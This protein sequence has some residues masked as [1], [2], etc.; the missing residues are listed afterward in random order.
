VLALL[1]WGA[2]SAAAK[3]DDDDEAYFGAITYSPSTRAHGWAYDYSSR[4]VAERRALR[5]CGRHAGDCVVT[6]RFRNG[7]GALAVG[8]DGYGSGWG[9]SRRLAERYAIQSCSRYSDGCAVIRWVCTT[10]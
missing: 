4:H 3:D 8:A 2:N 10:K 6:V 1:A 5:Q 7:C 9:V